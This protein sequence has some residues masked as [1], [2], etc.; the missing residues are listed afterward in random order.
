MDLRQAAPIV[1]A[2]PKASTSTTPTFRSAA[3][4]GP[5][6]SPAG[7]KAKARHSTGTSWWTAR[8][9][10]GEVKAGF[11]KEEI[12]RPPKEDPTAPDGVFTRVRTLLTELAG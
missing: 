6:A 8:A 4:A 3:A 2:G 10:A 5:T 7:T 9:T 12:L 11:T 1:P